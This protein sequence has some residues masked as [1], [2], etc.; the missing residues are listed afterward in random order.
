MQLAQYLL[1]DQ[2]GWDERSIVEAARQRTEQTVRLQ[3]SW[4]VHVLY[5]TAWVGPDGSINFR[6]DVYGRD[7]E[8]AQVLYR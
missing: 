8:L 1:R 3:R 5:W 6:D 4:P 7:K 2:S